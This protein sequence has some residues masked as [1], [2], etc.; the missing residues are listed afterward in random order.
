MLTKGHILVTRFPFSSRWGGEELH[1]IRLME[2]LDKK[3]YDACFLG[4]DPVLLEAF[5][6]KGF[7]VKKASLGKP[8]VNK[9]WLILFTLMSPFLFLKAGWL[10]WMARKK[11]TVDIL[12]SLSFG[13][14]LLMTPWAKIFGMKVLWLEHA[15]VGKWLTK[16]PWRVVYKWL[17][18]W[19]TVVVT[20]QAMRPKIEHLVKH[21]EVISCGVIVDKVSP[22][23]DKVVNFL[24]D[25]FAVGTVARLT[26]DKGVDRVVRLVHSK[27]D[28][29]LIIVGEGPLKLALEKEAPKDRVMFVDSLPRTQLMALYKALDLFILASTKMD[30]FGM[31]AAEAMWFGTPVLLTDQCGFAADLH[32]GKEA[33]IVP[34]KFAAMDKAV[35]KLMKD[36]E[37][38]KKLGEVGKKFVH[39]KYKLGEMVKSFES[40]IS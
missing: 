34:A 28:M 35:K 3:G 38:L 10:L 31:V 25:G 1:T 18:R 30:P 17:S 14:K 6:K 16:N 4:S 5:K 7:A 26:V 13:E 24:K 32:D 11:W 37:R 15:R 33:V 21:L 22:L 36:P 27:P 19:S 20:S 9:K 39:D 8:P 29:R 23:P 40:L 2:E 12:Y